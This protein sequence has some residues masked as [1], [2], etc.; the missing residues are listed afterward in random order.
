M[1]GAREL[2]HQALLSSDRSLD[3]LEAGCAGSADPLVE[4]DRPQLVRALTNLVRNADL[5]GGGLTCV[6]V[7]DLGAFVDVHVE[8]RGPGVAPGDKKRIFERFARAGG[9]KVGTGSGLGLSIVQQTARNH[10]GDVWCTDRPD[11]GAVFVLRLPTS[12]KRM[13]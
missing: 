3:L 8:D 13:P 4:V 2:V 9:H 5:H 10:R 7:L 1:I 6:R 12:P 11:G